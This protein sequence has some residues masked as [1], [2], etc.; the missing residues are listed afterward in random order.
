[1]AR[2]DLQAAPPLGLILERAALAQVAALLPLPVIDDLLADAARATLLRKIAAARGVGADEAALSILSYVGAFEERGV[3]AALAAHTT[4]RLL[5]RAFRRL[6][7]ALHLVGHAG[8]FA[9]TFALAT[10][11]DHYCARHHVGPGLD[12]ARARELRAV[13]D[14]AIA[15]ARREVARRGM[16]GAAERTGRLLLGA[17]RAVAGVLPLLGGAAGVPAER[18]P[19]G[20]RP[21][22]VGGSIVQRSMRAVGGLAGATTRG[23]IDA[24]VAAFDRRWVE[25]RT[26]ATPGGSAP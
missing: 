12:A 20:E 25:R 9:T 17:P 21:R 13:I 24:L 16:R 4:R 26:G 2:A 1:M 11:F 3:P 8:D 23:W 22:T 10:L 15:D 19:P 7:V 5:R 14:A 18:V 6:A